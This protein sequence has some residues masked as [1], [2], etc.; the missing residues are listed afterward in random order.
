MSELLKLIKQL[1]FSKFSQSQSTDFSFALQNNF[2][3]FNQFLVPILVIALFATITYWGMKVLQ[4]SSFTIDKEI[5]QTLSTSD[6]QRFNQ[7]KSLF[8]DIQLATQNILL[9][10]I[11]ITSD[12]SKS[13]LDGF[14]IFEIN[15][16]SSNAISIG[17]TVGNGI[18]LK[19]INQDSAIVSY[20]GRDIEYPLITTKAN[21]NRA[22]SKLN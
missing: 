16:K 3:T 10:G 4:I 1:S 8:G 2:R 15:G 18:T 17:E 14:A 9:R 7:S 21:Q 5:H 12:K 13:T 11:V 22:S 20:L 19:S 6:E